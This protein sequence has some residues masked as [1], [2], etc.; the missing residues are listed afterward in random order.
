M[1]RNS[2]VASCPVFS[3]VLNEVLSLNA[4]ESQKLTRVPRRT[5]LL[6]EVLSLNAQE[7]AGVH[8]TVAAVR[9]SSMKS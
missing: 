5:R 3:D 6:N 2:D 1:L 7:F 9:V 4:Q 8:G